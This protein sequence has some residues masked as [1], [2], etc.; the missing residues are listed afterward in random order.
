V[1]AL[2]L[3]LPRL[4]QE[5]GR[6]LAVKTKKRMPRSEL[7]ALIR[8]IENDVRHALKRL[9]KALELMRAAR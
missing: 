1:A 6:E 3:P 7:K 8:D 5:R 2:P 9:K 4:L